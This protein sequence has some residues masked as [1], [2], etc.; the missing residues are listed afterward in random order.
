MDESQDPSKSLIETPAEDFSPLV[1]AA[2]TKAAGLLG[3]VVALR[4]TFSQ[5]G[6]A[7]SAQVLLKMNHRGGF[8]CP[9]C[10]WPDPDDR[11]ALAE[12]CEN[13]AKAVA[14]E[15][16]RKRVGPEFFAEHSIVELSQQSDFELGKHG[17]LT[18]PMVKRRGATHYT[19]I[20]WSDAF[21]MVAKELNALADPN[22]AAFYTS[23]R[24]S[25]E[26]AFLYQLF[27][28]L[29]GTN[30]LPDCS[31]MCHESSGLGLSQAIGVGK[32]TVKLDDFYEADCILIA[33]QNPGTNH[34]RM[35][36]ALQKAARNGCKIIS[37]NPLREAGL[38]GFMNPQE[39]GG[40]LGQVTPI[41][42][43][44][45]PVRINGDVALVK[46]L[47]KLIL[48]AHDAGRP[49]L[50]Q[51]FIA[52]H[53][54]GFKEF[55]EDLRLASWD[56]IVAESGCSRALL[57][58]AAEII[59]GA[60]KMIACWAMGLT[61]HKN[62]VGNVQTYT[63]LLM[64]G[65]HLGRKGAGV[66]PVRGHSNVQG[67]RTMGIFERMPEWFMDKLG[68]EFSFTPPRE[69]GLD[70]VN[71][72]R[73]MHDG[74]VKV[75]LGMG[76][77]FLV[78]TPDTALVAA[79]MRKCRLTV[80]VSTKPNRSHLVTGEEALILPCLGRTEIDT[81]AS[82]EQ[83]VTV[84]DS[85]GVVHASRGNLKPGSEFLKS[86]IDIVAGL[87]EATFAAQPAKAKLV[88]W[89]ALTDNYDLIRDRIEHVIPGFDNYNA[90]VKEKEFY[91][92]NAVRDER[93]FNTS[94]KKAHFTV[95]PLAKTLLPEGRY[96][97]MTI[98][99]HDQFNTTVYG[100]NDRYRGITHGRRVLLMNVEDMQARG[101]KSG[102]HV[103]LT[104]H[105]EGQTRRAAHFFA[106][107]YEIPRQCVAS[108]Y[109]EANVLVPVDATADGSN[110]PAYKSVQISL[111]PSVALAIG[112]PHR[113]AS[114]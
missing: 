7:R 93:V 2:K 30:N 11:R 111:E 49:V 87:A 99:S 19:P 73:A 68:Q 5:L 75:F 57:E 97:L 88:D 101:L 72:I 92:P 55:E 98:R 3:V 34:P 76:G 10:A 84:E 26:A 20:S 83:F 91:L 89:R 102:D 100:L 40:M 21:A 108:Y 71:T 104:S 6:V 52:Q 79:G 45:L 31:N 17:R 12:F 96:L 36:S 64:L 86:E 110:Q 47:M 94:D 13:G 66:C 54:S 27:T 77:N 44:F 46:G 105:Y 56:E 39:V 4:D 53:T 9:S 63:N 14:D 69:H 67:D 113:E 106:V 95:H 16:T 28:R 25:N 22:E 70:T 38:V 58:E 29:L 8:D 1:G 109:P 24:T 37:I 114:T 62:G 112:A 35:L 80:H 65:G 82:G 15:A 85:M 41:A 18:H 81:Q 107:P 60:K 48:A 50:D 51:D 33:G 78:A 103:D 90:R 74:R 32:G 23:G 42:S 59:M 61:Q 43:L